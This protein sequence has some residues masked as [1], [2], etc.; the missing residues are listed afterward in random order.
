MEIVLWH[1]VKYLSLS[2]DII[3]QWILWKK[4]REDWSLCASRVGH[5]SLS[6]I[7]PTL[8]VLR[9][10]LQVQRVAV[11]CSFSTCWIWVLQYGL[12]KD[13]AYSSL[14]RTK[15]LYATSLV[16]LS[17]KANFLRRKPKVLVALDEISEICWPPIHV[18]C[19]CYT[20]MFCGLNVFQSLLMQSVVLNDL[21]VWVMP[22]HSHR[23]TFGHIEF[24]MPLGLP[25]PKTV[26]IILQNETVLQWVYRTQSS[27]NRRT[28]DL[29]LSVKSFMKIRKRIGAKNDPWGTPDKTGT[30]SEAWPSKTTCWLH[31]E[32]HELIHLWEDP[33]IP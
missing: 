10:P 29:I 2:I 17:A 27:A 31:P 12:Q 3:P 21:F 20:K 19:D 32:S 9:H 25:E 6:S 28:V 15:V 5:C 26:K 7:S 1:G 13:A 4:S 23:M 11:L 18:L 33:L 30:G 16:F 22:S 8:Q 24:H 14:G